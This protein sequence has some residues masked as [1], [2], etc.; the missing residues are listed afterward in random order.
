M[1]RSRAPRTSAPPQGEW[2]L[3]REGPG[4]PS[5][6]CPVAGLFRWRSMAVGGG[7]QRWRPARRTVGP[8]RPVARRPG[9]SPRPSFPALASL[10]PPS[11]EAL[12]LRL[13]PSRP[14]SVGCSRRCMS[15]PPPRRS[16]HPHRP[17]H[18]LRS[19]GSRRHRH[20]APP[21]RRGDA[22]R[23]TGWR[24]ESL[25]ALLY[26]VTGH[27]ILARNLRTPFGE[28][29]LVA[30]DPRRGTL[31]IIEV[32]TRRDARPSTVSRS[33][34][35]RLTRA[36][37]HLHGGVRR[38]EERKR[39]GAGRGGIRIDLVEVRLPRRWWPWPRPTPRI[40]RIIGAWGVER[41]GVRGA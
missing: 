6:G 25:V 14:R 17:S 4:S 32:K 3:P 40:R 30:R 27:P 38:R 23:G 34:Q 19:L 28:V 12:S 18:P 9:E 41:A 35:E 15:M 29:D 31:I 8:R 26:R 37:I 39:G 20:R 11:L 13:S 36:A 5:T 7:G 21:R 33:Q 16:P 22:R 10:A 24:G 2:V 1:R